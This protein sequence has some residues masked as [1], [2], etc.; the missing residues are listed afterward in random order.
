MVW[1]GLALKSKTRSAKD[2][3]QWV[4]NLT[5]HG[6]DVFFDDNRIAS[7]DCERVMAR[8]SVE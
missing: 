8:Q 6:F 5:R 4:R 1:P 7:R 2:T 3:I